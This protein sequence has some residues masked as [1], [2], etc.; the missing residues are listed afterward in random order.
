MDQLVSNAPR[1]RRRRVRPSQVVRWC[2]TVDPGTL[3]AALWAVKACR[4]V[5]FATGV[6]DLEAPPLPT[7]PAVPPSAIRGVDHVLWLRAE[8][9]LVRATIR[10][11]WLAAH[12]E[13]QDIIVGVAIGATRQMQAH[14]WLANEPAEGVGYEELVRVPPRPVTASRARRR[15]A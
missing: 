5:R 2:K 8:Q 14:A 3:R 10:Q 4:R 7:V 9:C 1:G 13:P 12:G 15:L 6:N 11:A